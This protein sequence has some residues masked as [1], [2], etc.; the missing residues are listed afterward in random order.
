MLFLLG[1]R[2]G[3]KGFLGQCC[4]YL[5]LPQNKTEKL[6]DDSGC[7]SVSSH[8]GKVKVLKSRCT[9]LGTELDAKCFNGSWKEEVS[10]SVKILKLCLFEIL[11]PMEC[12]ISR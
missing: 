1:G 10:N 8:V 3:D 12:W 6:T 4:G 2:V 11:I 9:K 7:S 5:T